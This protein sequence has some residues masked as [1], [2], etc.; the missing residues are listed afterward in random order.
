MMIAD[1]VD[2]EDI[3]NAF[4]ESHIESDIMFS[5]DTRRMQAWLAEHPQQKASLIQLIHSLEEKASLVLPEVRAHL[6][7]WSTLTA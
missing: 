7:Q 3:R 2:M 5:D 4:K 6:T 1:L